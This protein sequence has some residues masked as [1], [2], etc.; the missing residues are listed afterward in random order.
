MNTPSETSNHDTSI[1]SLESFCIEE[2]LSDASGPRALEILR[3]GRDATYVSFFTSDGVPVTAHYLEQAEDWEPGYVQC[4]GQDCPACNAGM[5]S[6]RFL[7]LPIVDRIMGRVAILRVPA[8]KGPGKLATEIMKV[9]A[10]PN[11]E[12]VVA[13]ISRDGKYTYVVEA[14][15]APD[16]DPEVVRVVQ[17]F[18]KLH[19]KGEIDLATSVTNVPAEEMITHPRLARKLAL[20]GL[21]P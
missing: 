2:E 11:R 18:T 3:V 1:I 8:Q 6:S 13:K 21:A 7:L 12:D 4:L 19:E 14:K 16:H 15:P 9:L 20:E 17:D 5:A 10:L